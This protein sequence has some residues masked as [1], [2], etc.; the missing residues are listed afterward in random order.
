MVVTCSDT[1]FAFF[2]Y[3]DED[4]LEYVLEPDEDQSSTIQSNQEE[5]FHRI[6]S[7][8]FRARCEKTRTK[9]PHSMAAALAAKAK[10]KF[11]DLSWSP[12]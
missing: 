6:C 9:S 10:E 2:L 3:S 7:S 12:C 8:S 1:V 11:S 5:E 4:L